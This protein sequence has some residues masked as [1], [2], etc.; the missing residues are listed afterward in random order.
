MTMKDYIDNMI[1]A[2]PSPA[3][4][5][6]EQL[7]IIIKDIVASLRRCGSYRAHDNCFS[8]GSRESEKQMAKRIAKI[9]EDKGY[10]VNLR[11][12]SDNNYKVF[13]L[14]IAM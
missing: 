5:Q 6:Q 14:S 4:L 3:T 10:A 2:I 13:E 9:F 12:Y 11:F 7:E 8:I 1:D